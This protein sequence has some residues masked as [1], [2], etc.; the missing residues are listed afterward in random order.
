MTAVT[1]GTIVSA[2]EGTVVTGAMPAVARDL[3]GLASYGWLFSAFLIPSTFTMLLCGKLADAFGRR[4]V[5]TAGMS[6]FLVGSALCGSA[7]SFGSLIAFRAVQG[8]GAGALQPMAMTIGAD[9]YKLEER[10]RVQAF[11]TAVWGLANVAGPVIGGWIVR[12]ASWRWVFLVNVPV[13]AVAVALLAAS[14]RDPARAGRARVGIG[15]ALLAGMTTALV[16]LWLSPNGLHGL[17]TRFALTTA[18]ALAVG[19]FVLHQSRGATPLLAPSALAQPAVR[20]G[21]AAGAGVGGILYPCAAY[22]PLWIV[23]RGR[24]DGLAAG[25]SLVPLLA[26]WAI[27]SGFSVRILV[28]RGMRVVMV[29]GFSIAF[30]GAVGLS[31]ATAS[32]ASAPWVLASLGV[33]GLGLGGVAISSV[34]APQS[35]VPWQERGAVTSAVFASR[36]LGGS[37]AVAALGAI[38]AGGRDVERFAGL[39]VLAALGALACANLAPS[40]GRAESRDAAL[41]A[42]PV[43][44]SPTSA[45]RPRSIRWVP[46]PFARA[47]AV[48]YARSCRARGGL[49]GSETR[50]SPV[51]RASARR[52][53]S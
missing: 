26:A 38:G 51:P 42:L 45:R 29:G 19:G 5:F 43:T 49:Q 14:Y 8:L 27:G 46:P 50:S 15:G 32:G 12:N 28:G 9:L 6:L 41:S 20:A 39:A 17:A 23:S 35:C 25:A 53:A 3:G 34:I 36:M 16:C 40:G 44:P 1:V 13:G 22:V 30:V 33:L 48:A 52:R 21:L 7:T 4:P 31:A 18:A 47:V 11:S 2:F 10:A 37:I 24:G